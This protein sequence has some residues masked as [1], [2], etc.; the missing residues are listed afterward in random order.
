[1]AF[2]LASREVAR[3]PP[4][5]QPQL[6]CLAL[7]SLPTFVPVSSIWPELWPPP[8]EQSSR[9]GRASPVTDP[10]PMLASAPPLGAIAPLVSPETRLT[11]PGV[12]GPKVSE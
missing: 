2:P 10:P 11:A 6:T 4:W 5:N 12:D 1:M 8:G 3:K 9:Y 7:R